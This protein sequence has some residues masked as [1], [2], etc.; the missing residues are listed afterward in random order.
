MSNDNMD[1]EIEETESVL[2]DTDRGE[3]DEDV[4]DDADS[5]IASDVIKKKRLRRK[6][7]KDS[8]YY[9]DKD[10]YNNCLK[11]FVVS[12]VC[13][14]RLGDLF[15][16][17]VQRCASAANFK[18]YTYRSEMESTALFFLLKYSKNFD[19]TGSKSKSNVANAFAYCT[20]IIHHAFLQIIQRE[21][22]HSKLKDVLIKD[23]PKINH[24][25]QRFSILDRI[26]D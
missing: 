15:M 11:D 4:V 9:I 13:G 16:L 25:T 23:Q 22:K 6:I 5:D 14:D 8:R 26:G 24:E 3:S 10:E 12:G 17:H 7:D 18:G 21:K 20:Q 2:D 1:S 19:W